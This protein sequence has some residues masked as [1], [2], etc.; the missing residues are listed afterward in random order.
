MFIRL[1]TNSLTTY[2]LM[3][4]FGAYTVGADSRG[5]I[6]CVNESSMPDRLG[7]TLVEPT[8][9][10]VMRQY[11]HDGDRE[12]VVNFAQERANEAEDPY[13]R[14]FWLSQV[15]AWSH[16]ADAAKGGPLP[17]KT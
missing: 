1:G 12:A 8:W 3:E 14:Q 16:Y 4:V 5:P 7:Y 17:E 6:W 13:D 15:I 2:T 10:L 11:L 9:E